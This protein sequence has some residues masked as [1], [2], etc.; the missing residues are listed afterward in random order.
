M[1]ETDHPMH[2]DIAI[3][4]GGMVGLSLAI[5][6]AQALPQRHVQ[7]IESLPYAGPSQPL[8]QPSF[9]ARSSAIGWGSQ[10]IFTDMGVWQDLARHM[11]AI[12]T[13]H[14]SDQGQLGGCKIHSADYAVA[15]L[16]YVVDNQWLGACLL[17]RAGALA[18]LSLLG[19]A[20]VTAL[21][22]RQSGYQLQV[23]H[24]EQAHTVATQLAVIADGAQ[25]NL[26]RL[27]GIGQSENDYRHSALIANIA[28]SEPH[29]GVA[30]ERFTTDGPVAILPRASSEGALIWTRPVD[31]MAA[32]LDASDDALLAQLQ[33]DFGPRLGRFTRIGERTAYPLKL[34]QA[35]E[36]IR[37]HLVVMGN[38][39]HSLHPVAGQGFNLSLR[40]CQCL[41]D[42]LAEAEA[43]DQALGSLAVM[44]RYQN[45]QQA[46]QAITTQF[47]HRLPQ[48]FAYPGLAA[49]AA[50][51]LGLL[52]LE[53]LPPAKHRMALQSMGV[54][55][56]I[57][58]RVGQ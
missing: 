55:R 13:V 4:G 31:Q 28:F 12:S 19:N 45:R 10:S 30:Y 20:S 27:V 57:H 56:F 49:A 18:N 34:T 50:R 2:T 14:V 38:A 1:P 52:G 40:D 46:D 43:S 51:G 47:S 8:F 25:S 17:S 42:T 6:L 32:L 21:Q 37:P 24:G 35:K 7:L 44:S 33:A 48:W 16:G 39:A 15:A 5:L 11:T 36:Q 9:D 22:P 3:L 23:Q 53:L 58:P 26:R 54:T 41:A 29:Q